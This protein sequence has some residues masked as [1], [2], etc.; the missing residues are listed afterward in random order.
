MNYFKCLAVIAVMIVALVWYKNSSMCTCSLPLKKSS[1]RFVK[2]TANC[3]LSDSKLE[4]RKYTVIQ[5]L[6]DRIQEWHELSDGYSF[7]FSGD[8]K[9]AEDLTQFVL[10]ER[11]CCSFVSFSLHFES[12]GGPIRL[13]LRGGKDV[14]EYVSDWLESVGLATL[15]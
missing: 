14:K 12:T 15:K 1:G 13:E 9:T 6:T 4:E 8:E 11:R 3:A 5:G 10:F 2:S 7:H